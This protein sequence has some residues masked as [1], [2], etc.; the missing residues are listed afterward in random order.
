MTKSDAGLY[1]RVFN[2]TGENPILN[3]D[4]YQEMLDHMLRVARALGPTLSVA[5]S[6]IIEGALPPGTYWNMRALVN[7]SENEAHILVSGIIY[8]AMT[9]IPRV[10][11]LTSTG[12][13]GAK[14][15]VF[16]PLLDDGRG[17]LDVC[18]YKGYRGPVLIPFDG[19]SAGGEAL[20][21]MVELA[22]S[23][24]KAA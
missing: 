17:L 12:P 13:G 18:S 21:K 24:A 9:G 16:Y 20:M 7:R 8:D 6:E 19:T 1:P 3:P 15:S 22:R 5:T 2:R 10:K 14:Q 23:L 11:C 4:A